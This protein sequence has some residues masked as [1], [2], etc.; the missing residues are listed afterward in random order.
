MAYQTAPKQSAVQAWN[1]LAGNWVFACPVCGQIG[2]VITPRL[3]W[4][5]CR[6][7]SYEVGLER[8][9]MKPQEESKNE[10]DCRRDW[11]F[12]VAGVIAS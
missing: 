7:C 12:Q 9:S 2:L 4:Y 8:A 1:N 5:S 3:F 10:V 6:H 11:A